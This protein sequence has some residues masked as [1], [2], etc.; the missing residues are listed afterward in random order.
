MIQ[1]N[2]K[3]LASLAVLAVALST[4]CA[5]KVAKAEPPAA[6]PAPATPTATL[7][8]NPDVIQQGQPTT[9]T[10]QTSNANDITIAGMGTLSASGSRTVT[11]SSSTTYTLVAKGPGG[12]SDAS[13]RVTVNVASAAATPGPSDA[14]LF[15][16]NVKDVYF[17]YDKASI[18]PNEAGTEEGDASFLAQHP[19]MK[20]MIEGHCDDRGS[21][22]YNLALGTSRAESVKQA[23]IQQGV[24]AKQLSTISYGKEKPFC[25]QENDQCWQENR[26][27]HFVFQQ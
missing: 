1:Q 25:M 16:R 14:D 3:I 24:P 22:E 26:V 15:A 13:A 21:E 20:V 6:P 2:A 18:R 7:A 23:L 8:A 27:G 10:W 12:S 5:K 17:D 4:G 11:P 9:L 19:S